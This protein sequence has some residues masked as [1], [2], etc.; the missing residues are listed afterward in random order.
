MGFGNLTIEKRVSSLLCTVS[1]SGVP[2]V[3]SPTVHR[4]R[5]RL[6]FAPLIRTIG[7][8]LLVESCPIEI[9]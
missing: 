8:R 9:A 5:G 2:S 3:P 7:R 1:T 6:L 4:T